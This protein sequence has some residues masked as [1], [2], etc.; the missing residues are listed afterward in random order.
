M[1]RTVHSHLKLSGFGVDETPDEM[2]RMVSS[3][4]DTAVVVSS[5]RRPV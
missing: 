1:E 3:C 5:P 2:E 4:Y